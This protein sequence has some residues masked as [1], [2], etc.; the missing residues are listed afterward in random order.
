[1]AGPDLPIHTIG[2]LSEDMTANQAAD[3]VKAVLETGGIGA[4]LYSWPGTGAEEWA[5][6]APLSR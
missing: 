5:E 2:G 3:M 4:S 6:L 1:V